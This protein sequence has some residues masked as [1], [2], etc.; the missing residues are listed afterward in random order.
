MNKTDAQIIDF[1]LT[2][3]STLARNMTE[4]GPDRA[5]LG[6]ML[7][8]AVRVP[9]HGKLTPWRFLVFQGEA[10]ETFGEAIAAAIAAERPDVGP[11]AIE[12]MRAFPL[13]APTMVTVVANPNPESRIPEWEQSLSAGAACH[14]LLLAAI[15]L[16]YAAQWLTGPAA[17]SAG[18]NRFLELAETDRIAGFIFVGS[19]SEKP[20]TERGR[21]ELEEVVRWY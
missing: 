17:Y 21:P 3:R 9:D 12:S 20:L 5:A 14:N 7:G 10:R 8:A 4:P 1:L 2:R 18:V 16:G 6:K 13:L 15:S 11:T 19:P